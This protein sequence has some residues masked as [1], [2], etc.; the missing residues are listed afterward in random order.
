MN[1]K[2]F[3]QRR[4]NFPSGGGEQGTGEF[5][6]YQLVAVGGANVYHA[7]LQAAHCPRQVDSV[8]ERRAGYLQRNPGRERQGAGYGEQ[9]AAGAEIQSRGKL[10][11]FLASV[12]MG[13]HKHGD[14]QR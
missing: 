14:G 9:D 12:V 5:N 10:K 7:R 11:K 4:S 13:P 8:R 6:P 3:S 2:S 1:E